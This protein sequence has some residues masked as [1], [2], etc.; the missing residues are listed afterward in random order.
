MKGIQIVKISS[1]FLKSNVMGTENEGI[2][3]QYKLFLY[4]QE[5]GFHFLL[6]DANI[7]TCSMCPIN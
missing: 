1:V 4:F 7:L 6:N 3:E 2:Y 5:L